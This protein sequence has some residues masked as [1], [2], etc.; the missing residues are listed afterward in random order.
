M[1][2]RIHV[3]IVTPAGVA[4]ERDVNYVNLP[5][6]EGSVGVLANHAPMLC[7]VGRGRIRLR[8]EGGESAFSVAGGVASVQDNEVT[9][10][11]EEA[12]IEE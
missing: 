4:F 1:A 3:R 9:V 6:P 11:A 2:D 12:G 10:L 8:F 7:A 5:T